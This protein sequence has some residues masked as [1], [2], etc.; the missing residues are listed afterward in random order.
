MP[1]WSKRKAKVS[2]GTS[3]SK[4]RILKWVGYLTNL[5]VILGIAI[6]IWILYG[7]RI[8]QL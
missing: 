4:A 2:I 6:L 5:Y 7:D 8:K 1:N 3:E